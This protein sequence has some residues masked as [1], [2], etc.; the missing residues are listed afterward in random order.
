MELTTKYKR[1]HKMGCIAMGRI[2]TKHNHIGNGKYWKQYR[3][4]LHFCYI[5][6]ENNL[7]HKY[8]RKHS[9]SNTFKYKK[10]N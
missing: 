2:Y 5:G 1:L 3:S 9:F 4:F 8:F 7:L 10:N 6:G